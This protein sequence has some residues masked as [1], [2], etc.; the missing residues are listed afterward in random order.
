MNFILFI[1]LFDAYYN[2]KPFY[3]LA[4]KKNSFELYNFFDTYHNTYKLN[5]IASKKNS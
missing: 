3:L 4:F 1:N 5:F 2:A